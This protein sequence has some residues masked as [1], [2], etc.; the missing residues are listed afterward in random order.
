[1]ILTPIT[2]ALPK[3]SHKWLDERHYVVSQDNA[4]VWLSSCGRWYFTH[5]GHEIVTNSVTHWR[6]LQGSDNVHVTEN[7]YR[8]ELLAKHR[9]AIFVF[10]DNLLRRGKKGQA[11]I[12]DEPN[13]FGIATKVKPSTT[14]DSYFND[15]DERH[16]EAII[17][18]IERL[19]KL[20]SSGKYIVFPKAGIGTGLSKMPEKCPRLFALLNEFLKTHFDLSNGC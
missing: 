1:M 11:V 12:R 9:S 18:D 8:P 10:G 16:K 3:A 17:M 5:Q 15:A 14:D 19:V 20:R 7:L 13:A 2:Q 4:M 6:E